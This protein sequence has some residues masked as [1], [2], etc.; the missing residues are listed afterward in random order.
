M[1]GPQQLQRADRAKTR[2]GIAIPTIGGTI[3]AVIVLGIVLY[4]VLR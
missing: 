1:T 4:L 3:F 2:M